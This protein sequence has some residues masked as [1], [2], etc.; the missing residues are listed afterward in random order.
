VKNMIEEQYKRALKL[1]KEHEDKLIVLAE[2]LLENE[3]IYFEDAER[4]LGTRNFNDEYEDEINKVRQKNIERL[5]H[6]KEEE[7]KA[8]EEK[9][10]NEKSE[11]DKYDEIKER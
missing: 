10:A 3:V 7:E 5:K 11:R 2:L 6:K 8:E 1:L 4:I 9:V